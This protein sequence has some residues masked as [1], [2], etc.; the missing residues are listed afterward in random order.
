MDKAILGGYICLTDVP[1]K[2]IRYANGDGTF[3]YEMIKAGVFTKALKSNYPSLMLNHKRVI[4]SNDKLDLWEDKLGLRFKAEVTDIHTIELALKN[5]LSGCSFSFK[6]ARQTIDRY[7]G[8][9]LRI[10]EE[11]YLYD[12][13]ILSIQPQYRSIVTVENIPSSLMQKVQADIKD[14]AN[15]PRNADLVKYYDRID[16]LIK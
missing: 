2:P 10:I 5:K 13:S 15:K 7:Q 3:F 11:M 16:A 12:V 4:T 8:S 14:R 1:S 9:E 6:S